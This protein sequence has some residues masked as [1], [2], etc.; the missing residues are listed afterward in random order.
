MTSAD[1][2]ANL[3]QQKAKELLQN[4]WLYFIGFSKTHL[5]NLKYIVKRMWNA[6]L[7]LVGIPTSLMLSV[8]KSGVG[9]F[10]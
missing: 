7:I 9:G 8:K 4:W 2:R 10:T 1:V 6:D 3:K 5:K